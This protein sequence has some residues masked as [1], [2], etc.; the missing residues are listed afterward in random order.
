MR[1][2]VDAARVRA[3]MTAFAAAHPAEAQ[4][5]LVGGAS[6]VLNGWRSTTLDL[7]LKIVPDRDVARIIPRLKEVLRLNIE[8]ASPDQFIPELPGW[9]ERS[10]VVGCEGRVVF[11]HFDFY[12][13]AL[14]KIERG[15]ERDLEDVRQMVARGLVVPATALELF[16]RIEPELGRYPAIDPPTFRR[17]VE[18]AFA[19][20]R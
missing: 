14:A 6:A 15:F 17:S 13:Q 8:M 2:P 7:D 10:P 5:Y 19:R 18:A 3:F 20:Q 1:P 9:K 4:V 16:D 12:A 11:H